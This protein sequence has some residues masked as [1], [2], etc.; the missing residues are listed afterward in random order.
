MNGSG[1]RFVLTFFPI[2]TGSSVYSAAP[3]RSFV[4]G[5]LP[6]PSVFAGPSIGFGSAICFRPWVSTRV[7]SYT[8]HWILLEY[9]RAAKFHAGPLSPNKTV[10][11]AGPKKIP[12]K[13]RNAKAMVCG[14]SG[15]ASKGFLPDI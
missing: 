12:N 15:C 3:F 4:I 14:V 8:S 6:Y 11:N 5:I 10:M 13:N 1:C 2:P 7:R 9:S